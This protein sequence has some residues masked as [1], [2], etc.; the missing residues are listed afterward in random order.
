[1]CGHVFYGGQQ[2]F[3][4]QTRVSQD[5]DT[6]SQWSVKLTCRTRALVAFASSAWQSPTETVLL[7]TAMLKSFRKIGHV[8]IGISYVA[9]QDEQCL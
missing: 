1:M 2:V 6:G 7:G 4:A 9:R 8:A 5:C 3:V